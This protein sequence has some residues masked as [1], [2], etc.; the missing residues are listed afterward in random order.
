MG[1]LCRHDRLS[2]GG[3]TLNEFWVGADPG[4][5]GNFGLAFLDRDGGLSCKT[6]SSV[7]E[8]V[9]QIACKGEPLGLGIDAPMWWSSDKFGRR[10]ADKRIRDKLIRDKHKFPYGRVQWINSLRGAALVGGMMLALLVRK[11][12]QSVPI[13]ESH[14]KA[15]LRALK[16]DW[17]RFAQQFN[18]SQTWKNEHERDAA[19]GAV[20]AR[21][22]FEEQW[23]T[24]LALDRYPLEQ[25]PCCYCLAPMHY[26]WPEKI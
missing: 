21:E 25:D 14:P 12:F 5:K 2:S 19:I 3:E 9:K 26:F 6:V 24:D 10:K 7:D 22:G 4:G 11:K 15:L 23:K 18:I 1:N 16:I 17:P 13:T 20:C 8:A